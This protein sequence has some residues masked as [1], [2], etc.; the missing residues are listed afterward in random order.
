MVPSLRSL[1]LR[2]LGGLRSCRVFDLVA[3]S[4]WRRSRLLILCYHGISLRDEH[5]WK[6]GLYMSR[7]D[8]AARLK[9]IHAGGY[10]VLPL[11]EA[12]RRLYADDLPAKALAITF[13]DGLYDFYAQ[14]WP[15]LRESGFPVTV[16]LTTYYSEYN[17]PVFRLIC[18]YMIWQKRGALIELEPGQAIDLR[19]PES[20][21][22]ELKKLD[23]FARANHLSGRAK[24][25]LAQ[26]FAS[27]IGADW[28]AILQ[29][30]LLHLMN[31]REAGDLARA[32]VDL[33]LHTHRHRTPRDETLFRRELDDNASRLHD[34]TGQ[35][36]AHFCYPSGV[37]YPGYPE[38]LRRWGV[39]SAVT[40]ETG[41]AEASSDAMLLPRLC[42][43][44]AL[45]AVE[46]EAWL[47][48]LPRWFPK[49]SYPAMDSADT[50]AD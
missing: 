48:G 49:R 34:I 23:D 26:S 43:H 50:D 10:K 28:P 21:A 4:R 45:T 17:R 7:D 39:Q 37:H 9:S 12:V 11:A 35:I 22:G 47:C 36:P 3:E 20:R 31:P 2:T 42:D 44:S 25:E 40:C 33:Q 24:D 14:A 6:P 32:G 29:Q 13:D 27:L 19:T 46:F 1:K 38:W 5:C 41:M 18:D 15:L 30:R 16:Y 8:F